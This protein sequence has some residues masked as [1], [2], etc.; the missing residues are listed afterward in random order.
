MKPFSQCKHRW[1]VPISYTTVARGFEETQNSFWMT[2]NEETKTVELDQPLDPE[3]PLIVNVQQT[4]FY[5]FV[6]FSICRTF[7]KQVVS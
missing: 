4:G 2:P 1:W 3:E 6:A 5:R 7:Y